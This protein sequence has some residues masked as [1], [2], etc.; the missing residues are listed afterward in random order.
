MSISSAANITIMVVDDFAD[1]R[2]I[3][4][5]WLEKRGYH[6]IEAA[7]GREAVET[8]KRERPQLI[9]MDLYLPEI[10][11]YVATARIRKDEELRDVPIVAFSAYGDTQ[12]QIDPLAVGFNEYV[13]K[14]FGPEVFGEILDRF[15]PKSRSASGG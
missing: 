12:L 3:L 8:A 9:L 1:I 10:D 5:L 15:L 13:S 7:D 11:G 6:V 4:R 14:P 2:S